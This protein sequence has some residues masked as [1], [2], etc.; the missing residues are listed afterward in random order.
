MFIDG[1]WREAEKGGTFESFNPATGEPLGRIPAGEGID[2]TKAI[3]AADR[4]F[5]AWSSQTAY[6]R[7]QFLYQAHALMMENLEPLSRIMTQ[8]QGKPIKAAQNEVR[9]AA[10]FLLWYAEEA[11]RVYGRTIPSARADQRFLVLQGS[12]RF[13]TVSREGL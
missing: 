5:Q 4:A 7:S 6:Q 12:L 9:Y 10:D 2:A 1:K 3:V 8:E 11:K 13:L